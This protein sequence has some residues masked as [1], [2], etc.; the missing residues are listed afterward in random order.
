MKKL[1]MSVILTAAILVPV[2]IAEAVTKVT[3]VNRTDRNVYVALYMDGSTSGW[4]TIAPHATWLYES[5]EKV[6]NVG[7][8]AEGR[9]DGRDMIYWGGRTRFRGMFRGWVHPTEPF[10][11]W[12][13]TARQNRPLGSR[14]VGFRRVALAR[15]LDD[16]HITNFVATVTL[17]ENPRA[18]NPGSPRQELPVY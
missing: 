7:Y 9:A 8:Y 3:F 12:R 14:E 2:L 15:E 16:E 5:Q 10:N 17:V 11:I 18:T 6:W 4:Y 1:L 13:R